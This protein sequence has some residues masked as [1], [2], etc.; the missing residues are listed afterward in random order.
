MSDSKP[1]TQATC[2]F[3]N[4]SFYES[5][6]EGHFKICTKEK[7]FKP[8]H[9]KSN[10]KPLSPSIKNKISALAQKKKIVSQP[11]YDVMKLN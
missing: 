4:R 2:P 3:C 1:E 11:I 6:L 7:P 5:R 9:N 10:S 8:L